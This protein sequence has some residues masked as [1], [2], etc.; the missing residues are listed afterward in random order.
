M[1]LSVFP[2]L[3]GLGFFTLT[4]IKSEAEI[5]SNIDVV[6]AL[7]VG[8][9]TIAWIPFLNQALERFILISKADLSKNTPFVRKFI[10]V[11][12]HLQT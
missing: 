9:I 2:F 4:V 5:A 1:Y 11:F 3:A 7:V 6:F 12:S 10:S 8:L